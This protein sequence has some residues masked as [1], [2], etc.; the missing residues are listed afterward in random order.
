MHAKW[1][2]KGALE[3]VPASMH[4]ASVKSRTGPGNQ[5]GPPGAGYRGMGQPPAMG[6]GWGGGP[7]GMQMQGGWGGMSSTGGM[8]PEG[9][10]NVPNAH[11]QGRGRQN[12]VGMGPPGSS[13]SG[14]QGQAMPKHP[15]FV[16]VWNVSPM[17]SEQDLAS[18]IMEWDFEPHRCQA[19]SQGT[20]LL[21]FTQ[22]WHANSLVV[23]LDGTNDVLKCAGDQLTRMA[24][25][26]YETGKWS[27]EDVPAVFLNPGILAGGASM[28]EA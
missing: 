11:A 27:A 23:S 28:R 21:M 10:W 8:P 14:T 6:T 20:F 3:F 22:S 15:T 17:Y 19:V 12:F 1:S 25:Y 5:M 18:E 4:G 13:V 9:Q 24:T 2:E 7:P 26:I 16:A